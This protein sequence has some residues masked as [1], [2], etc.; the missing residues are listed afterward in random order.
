MKYADAYLLIDAPSEKPSVFLPSKLVEYLYMRKPILAL[1]P[2]GT[3]RDII[4]ETNT[5][6]C[7]YPEDVKSIKESFYHLPTLNI[8]KNAD[9]SKYNATS[10]VKN[11]D[12]IIQSIVKK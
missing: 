5:G 4:K 6:V 2:E 11:L 10:C 9:I 8:N 3:S 7:I 12:L 1:T